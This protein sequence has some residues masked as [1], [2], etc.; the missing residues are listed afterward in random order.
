MDK[1]VKKKYFILKIFASY[2]CWF[3][4]VLSFIIA[5]FLVPEKIFYGPWSILGI[6]YALVFSVVVTCTFRV[7]K[8]K[9]VNMKKVGASGLSIIS[10][11]LGLG[12]M[13]V[14]G[15]GAPV[16]G[17]TV[18]VSIFSLIAPGVSLVFWD[19][20]AT[21]LIFISIIIQLISL[22]FLKCFKKV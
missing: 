11:I 20:F 3:S 19:N 10:A 22:Y 4:L 14:C 6:I 12:A 17:A 7:I 1:V 13:Q 5:Y 21:P 16:C 9:T 8:E 2:Y 18:G 15:I